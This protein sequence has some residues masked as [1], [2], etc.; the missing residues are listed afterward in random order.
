MPAQAKDPASKAMALRQ[1]DPQGLSVC[2]VETHGSVPGGRGGHS[3]SLYVTLD[4][5]ALLT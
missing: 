4:G 5:G 2:A 3:V 1:I